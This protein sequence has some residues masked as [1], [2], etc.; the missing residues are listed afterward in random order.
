MR[1]D[2]WRKT[3]PEEIVNDALWSV[4]AYRLGLFAGDLGWK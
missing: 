3:V 2:E 4:E 1:F